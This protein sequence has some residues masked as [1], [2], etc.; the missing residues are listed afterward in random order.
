MCCLEKRQKNK[1]AY[2][3]DVAQGNRQEGVRV[4]T[5]RETFPPDTS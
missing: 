4:Q 5:E 2:S 3:N 1:E